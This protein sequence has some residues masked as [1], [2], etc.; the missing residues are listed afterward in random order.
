MPSM[1]QH[2]EYVQTQSKARAFSSKDKDE[3]GGK[4]SQSGPHGVWMSGLI[5]PSKSIST[6]GHQHT[7]SLS[8]S[9]ILGQLRDCIILYSEKGFLFT[10][11][12]FGR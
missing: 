11:W 9:K 8:R 3:S 12:R 4:F 7:T 2:F 6:G 10:K 5:S 1:N